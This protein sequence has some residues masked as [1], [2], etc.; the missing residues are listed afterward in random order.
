MERLTEAH[1]RILQS[2]DTLKIVKSTLAEKVSRH[3][4]SETAAL[5][6]ISLFQRVAAQSSCAKLSF[7]GSVAGKIVLSVNTSASRPAPPLK[8]RKIDTSQ[9]EAHRAIEKV[10]RSGTE[11]DKIRKE[12][13]EVAQEAIT[14]LLRVRGA[15]GENVIESWTVSLRKAGDWGGRQA[16]ADSLPQ[17][18]IGARV[19]AGVAVPLAEVCAALSTFQDGMVTTSMDRVGADFRLPLSTQGEAAEET[20][21]RSLLLLATVPSAATED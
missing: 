17:L 6:T 20:G 7:V 9:E 15:A 4:L 5:S 10:K 11:A 21:Q 19:T 8:K 13:F 3:E 16:N 18:F 12:T 2:A 14:A 1:S